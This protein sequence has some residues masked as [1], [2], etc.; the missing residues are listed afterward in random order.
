MHIILFECV[1]FCL[2]RVRLIISTQFIQIS[3]QIKQYLNYENHRF[4]YQNKKLKLNGNISLT[5]S[6][7]PQPLIKSPVVAAVESVPGKISIQ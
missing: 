6:K 3:A 1:N 2:L 7:F 4:S 5:I